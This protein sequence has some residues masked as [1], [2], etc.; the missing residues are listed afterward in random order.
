L[1][2]SRLKAD[3][4]TPE[5]RAILAE[6][7]RL[8]GAIGVRSTPSFVIGSEL[9]SGAMDRGGFQAL[10]AKAE[11]EQAAATTAESPF[12]ASAGQSSSRAAR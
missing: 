4:E 7:Q 9:V 5:V 2:I 11:S 12:A 8:A 1:D 6:N 3:M 10:I